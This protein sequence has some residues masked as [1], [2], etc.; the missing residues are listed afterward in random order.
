MKKNIMVHLLTVLSLFG[1]LL[2]S[3]C[4]HRYVGDY[5]VYLDKKY[6]KVEGY[7][8]KKLD[9][10]ENQKALL[11]AAT[12]ELKKLELAFYGP[13]TIRDEVYEE[14]GKENLDKAK[15]NNIV[16][17]KIDSITVQSDDLIDRLAEFQKALTP[18]QREKLIKILKKFDNKSRHVRWRIGL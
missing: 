2:F 16:K 14:F 12:A 17:E 15:L 6:E 4:A 11:V 13:P 9:L 1:L 18:E 8:A 3:G 5:D 7:F 10:D